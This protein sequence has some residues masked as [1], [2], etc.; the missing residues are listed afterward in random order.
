MSGK[1]SGGVK[2]LP[3]NDIETGELETTL[4]ELKCATDVVDA[5]HTAMEDG[6]CSAET[7][8][9]ALFGAVMYLGTVYHQFENIIYTEGSSK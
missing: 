2:R 3:R 5:V 1:T 6:A 9:D 4:Y 7:F 8:T